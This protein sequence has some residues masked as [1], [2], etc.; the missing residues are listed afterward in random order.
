MANV[1]EL[2]ITPL[3]LD[4]I[5]ELLEISDGLLLLI[6]TLS[7]SAKLSRVLACP[8]CLQPNNLPGVDFGINPVASDRALDLIEAPLEATVSVNSNV[9]VRMMLT[10]ELV[11]PLS[12][13]EK[14]M[15]ATDTENLGAG[16]AALV[17]PFVEEEPDA[18]LIHLP[19]CPC[20]SNGQSESSSEMT[21][22]M[23]GVVE[24]GD[25]Q[26]GWTCRLPR[27]RLVPLYFNILDSILLEKFKDVLR[28]FVG[29]VGRG[30]AGIDPNP[31]YDGAE[32]LLPVLSVG[33]EASGIDGV[34]GPP[35]F[36]QFTNLGA[37]SAPDLV[38]RGAVDPT[39]RLGRIVVESAPGLNPGVFGRS[40]TVEEVRV[41]SIAS[42]SIVV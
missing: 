28:Y 21:T 24:G 13:L 11:R 12:L 9:L 35:N 42:D 1:A 34:A 29:A 2:D 19:L 14:D 10:P 22:D 33:D 3:R 32:C 40:C 25:V 15:A 8:R 5:V 26:K 7:S 38:E 27:D 36:H 39:K 16:V 37:D 30:R 20:G 4:V 17:A 6:Q 23:G 31:N 41:I 18:T